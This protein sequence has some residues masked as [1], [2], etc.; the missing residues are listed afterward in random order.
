MRC[1]QLSEIMAFNSRST[2]CRTQE[3]RNLDGQYSDNFQPH[4]SLFLI[5][6]QRVVLKFRW[7][8]TRLHR[9]IPQKTVIFNLDKAWTVPMGNSQA[10][11]QL[12]A[13]ILLQPVRHVSQMC[14]LSVYFRQR[15]SLQCVRS[16]YCSNAKCVGNSLCLFLTAITVYRW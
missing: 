1:G 10:S 14:F 9:V 4:L 3:Y 2:L 16:P 8:V 15:P 12:E 11:S 6:R 13:F 5:S 7:Q